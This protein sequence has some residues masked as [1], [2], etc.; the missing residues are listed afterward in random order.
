MALHGQALGAALRGQFRGSAVE[1]AELANGGETLGVKDG[2]N[3]DVGAPS[4]KGHFE[5]ELIALDG[6]TVQGGLPPLRELRASGRGDGVAG[7]AAPG[8]AGELAVGGDEAIA[9]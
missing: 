4:G 8:G 6:V 1:F 2:D 3:V 9:L 5:H 7:G